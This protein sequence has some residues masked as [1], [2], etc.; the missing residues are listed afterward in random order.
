M[1]TVRENASPPRES[2]AFPRFL[3][4]ILFTGALFFGIGAVGSAVAAMTGE[5]RAVGMS[6]GVGLSAW[7]LGWL[8]MVLWSGR[9]IPRWFIAS[10]GIADRRRSSRG[11]P[12]QQLVDGNI[13]HDRDGRPECPGFPDHNPRLSGQAPQ[14]QDVRR[15]LK[16]VDACEEAAMEVEVHLDEAAVRRYRRRTIVFLLAIALT[17]AGSLLRARPGRHARGRGRGVVRT[18]DDPD[19]FRHGP[20]VPALGFVGHGL[21][22]LPAMPPKAVEG[23]PGRRGRGE[24]PLFLRGL[25]RHL[26]S[27]MGLA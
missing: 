26:G 3:A 21:L 20:V 9:S 12:V 22:S 24:L 16:P 10:F 8:G 15:A 25:P 4:L 18:R 27:R 13:D 1:F 6:V 23:L 14:A 17:F 2:L 11:G 5:R 7:M 19:R